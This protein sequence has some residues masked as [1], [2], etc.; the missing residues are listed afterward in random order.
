MASA[1]DVAR[2]LVFLAAAETEPDFLT[3]LRL[4]KLLYYCQG[5][6]LAETGRPLFSERIEAW[7]TGPVVPDAFVAFKRFAWLP[8]PNEE[9]EPPERLTDAEVEFI[10]GVW[11][12]YRGYSSTRLYEM[13]QADAP[14]LDARRG[15][16]L[17]EDSSA[18]L[19]P[20]VL[21]DYFASL[22]EATA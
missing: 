11:A 15:C 13:V 22:L 18:E 12:D 3:P 10:I 16:S 6:H 4:Q 19:T 1:L 5:W 14:W 21:K 20:A 17:I 9:V 8:I 2:Q 7:A